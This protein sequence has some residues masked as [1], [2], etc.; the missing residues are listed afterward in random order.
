MEYVYFL[1]VSLM[2]ALFHTDA[3]N[4]D[5]YTAKSDHSN[6]FHQYECGTWKI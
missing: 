3:Y 4:S 6:Y 1:H 5:N 2:A